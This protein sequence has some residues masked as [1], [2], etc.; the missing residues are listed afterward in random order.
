MEPGGLFGP[1]GP[2]SHS[3]G[4][5][6]PRGPDGPQIL[7]SIQSH[8]EHVDKAKNSNGTVNFET[9]KHFGFNSEKTGCFNNK[10]L[11]GKKQTQIVPISR[12]RE[13]KKENFVGQD[14]S[15]IYLESTQRVNG[16]DILQVKYPLKISSEKNA[17][18][19]G[20]E[21]IQKQEK[22]PLKISLIKSL[23]MLVILEMLNM[24]EILEILVMLDINKSKNKKRI[25]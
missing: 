14:A 2:I 15:K 17:G 10:I 8:E 4:P 3:I 13:Y 12:P 22:D 9:L 1:A 5:M 25:L 18:N 23:E 6:E 24:L 16:I 20:H 11:E 7:G 21:R 19:T